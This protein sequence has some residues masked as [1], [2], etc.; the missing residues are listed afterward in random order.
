[1]DNI[2][3]AVR[4]K[5]LISIDELS[6]LLGKKAVSIIDTRHPD[7][8]MENHIP[9]AVNIFEI[10]TYLATR[11]N[12]GTE[13]LCRTFAALFGNAGLCGEEQV[14]VYEDNMDNGYGR[15]C[16]G[17]FILSYMGHTNVQV[18]HGGY[19]AWLDRNMPVTVD[20]PAVDKKI[21]PVRPDASMI[22]T[23]E[24]MLAV[25][26][27]PTIIKL[28][29]RDYSEWIGATSSPYG[30]SFVPRTGR[31][32][33]SVWIE[34]YQVMRQ[35]GP[36]PWFKS[37]EELRELFARVGI[38]N[39]STVFV[40]CFKGARSSNTSIALKLAGVKTVRNYFFSWNDWSR[41]PSLPI[42]NGYPRKRGLNR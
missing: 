38:T 3:D 10:F 41:D 20:V 17:R 30:P 9:G 4:R 15:S 27:D 28:D 31:I 36:I 29:C 22:V 25:L 19:Q 23:T 16:R 7:E 2:D 11:E 6:S 42:E 32:P 40:Y 33:G 1:M 8:Y 34:W 18:L 13:E 37:P 12:G 26:D 39:D 35:D 5:Y 14:I 21:F 24:E